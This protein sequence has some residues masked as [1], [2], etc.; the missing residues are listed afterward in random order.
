MPNLAF[1]PWRRR[2]RGR[3][4]QHEIAR[5]MQRPLDRP[6]QVRIHRQAGLIPKDAQRP[7]PKPRPSQPLQPRLHS[8]CQMTVNTVAVRNERVVSHGPTLAVTRV[9]PGS[10]ARP[11]PAPPRRYLPIR[12]AD[13]SVCALAHTTISPPLA[14]TWASRRVRGSITNQ[15][16]PEHQVNADEE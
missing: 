8:R 15:R 3:R 1:N 11:R 10:L 7:P 5:L 14:T 13:A 4:E 9:L 2:R 16:I 6:P 12:L